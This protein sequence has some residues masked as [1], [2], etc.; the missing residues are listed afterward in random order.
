MNKNIK[1]EYIERINK[2]LQKTNDLELLDFILK[3]I[4]KSNPDNNV[5]KSTPK[6]WLY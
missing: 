3:L 6:S 1:K 2:E 4:V 5:Q